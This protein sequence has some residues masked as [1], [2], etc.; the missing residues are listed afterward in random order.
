M[1]KI[2]WVLGTR[3]QDK[4]GYYSTAPSPELTLILQTV[5]TSSSETQ[6]LLLNLV[7]CLPLYLKWLTNKLTSHKILSLFDTQ[8]FLNFL[9]RNFTEKYCLFTILDINP[10]F[11]ARQVLPCRNICSG[12]FN[13]AKI[14]SHP[15]CSWPCRPPASASWVTEIPSLLHQDQLT[16]AFI[17][18]LLVMKRLN[19]PCLF[20]P[21]H[22]LHKWQK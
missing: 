21:Y 2:P 9:I 14:L 4:T 7:I 22:D 17:L 16:K 6:M 18:E 20:H 12:F 10:G 15:G 19:K 3:V 8:R 11:Q 1:E 5:D 13:S